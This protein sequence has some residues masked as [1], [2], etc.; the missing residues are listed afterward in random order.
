[1]I[2]FEG[3]DR[4]GKSTAAF[5]ARRAL[6]TWSYRHH[7]KPPADPYAYFSWFMADAHPRV[8][9]DRCWWSEYAYGLAYRGAMPITPHQWRYL[10][11]AAMSRNA[12]VILMEDS[13]DNILS[14]WGKDEMYE[15]S[16]VREVLDNYGNIVSGWI[17]RKPYTSYLRRAHATLGDLVDERGQPTAHFTRLL[18]DFDQAADFVTD[19]DILPASVGIGNLKPKFVVL[20]EAPGEDVKGEL[21]PGYP[22]DR[23][24]ASEWF[25]RAMDELG[26][27]WWN[28]YYTN[29]SAFRKPWAL[30]T[31]L[32][33]LMPETVLCL[34]SKAA[35]MMA[36]AKASA[37][38]HVA[39]G[40]VTH[41]MH[42]RRF[43]FNEF[44]TWRD[45]VGAV[46]QKY[47]WQQ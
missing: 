4:C 14:R 40:T 43:H 15:P 39:W 8:V 42:A 34:G 24:K 7:T 47:R 23:G 9:V 12:T 26:V 27:E 3:L 46:L 38:P 16:K 35:T 30:G 25:W 1:M 31:Y 45:Q 17:E 44:D 22:L 41:P 36:D 2:I 29:A 6:G 5:A 19:H 33:A 28:G 13:V 21:A 20:G 32:C 37:P 11:L 10:E 18:T